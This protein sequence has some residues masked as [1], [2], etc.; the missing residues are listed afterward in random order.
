MTG[1]SS[2]SS[3][4]N[5]ATPQ[6]PVEDTQTPSATQESSQSGRQGD[7]VGVDPN[8]GP[9]IVIQ[10]NEGVDVRAPMGLAQMR[11]LIDNEALSTEQLQ[12][13]GKRIRELS[14]LRDG[15]SNRR[16]RDQSDSDSD[17]DRPRK[18]RAD[19]DLKY[20]TI[21][22][23]KLGATLRQ[24]TNWKMEMTRAFDGAPYK[25]DNDRAK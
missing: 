14:H 19:H 4:R 1:R 21:K 13:L 6:E 17:S 18:R 5:R 8:P 22:E 15:T 11:H 25:Y 7:G 10:H 3:G 12:V 24:W 23:L 16:I 9:T 2:R 20:D